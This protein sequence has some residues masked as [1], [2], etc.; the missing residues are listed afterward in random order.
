MLS[1]TLFTIDRP[2]IQLK[3]VQHYRRHWKQRLEGYCKNIANFTSE[4]YSA[5]NYRNAILLANELPIHTCYK[6]LAFH[7]TN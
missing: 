3:F 2:T 5:Y 4:F 1:R 6:L 7:Q